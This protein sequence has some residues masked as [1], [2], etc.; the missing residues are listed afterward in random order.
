MKI[1]PITLLRKLVP[2]FREPPVT[3]KVVP[4]ADFGLIIVPKAGHK[5]TLKKIDEWERRRKS[6]MRLLEHSLQ[7]VNVFK[8]A[9]RNFIFIFVFTKAG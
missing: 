8:E 3:L 4:K 9:S 6:Y 2:A 7:L 1:L 5:C